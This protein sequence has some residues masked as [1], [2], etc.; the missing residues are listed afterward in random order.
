MLP[1][2]KFLGY[3]NSNG[4]PTYDFIGTEEEF[5]EIKSK[6]SCDIALAEKKRSLISGFNFKE[7]ELGEIDEKALYIARNKY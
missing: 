3:E 1:N 7:E 6:I 4:K 2:F 5:N